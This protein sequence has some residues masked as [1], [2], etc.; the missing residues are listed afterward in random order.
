MGQRQGALHLGALLWR[1]GATRQR[2]GAP[3]A[4]LAERLGD[5]RQVVEHRH[6]QV[7]GVGLGVQA[8]ARGIEHVDQQIELD[9]DQ[10]GVA[11]ETLEAVD[12]ALD[13]VPGQGLPGRRHGVAVL[14]QPRQ[15]ISPG[16]GGDLLERSL[17]GRLDG[18]AAGLHRLVAA[19]FA[20]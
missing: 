5:R 19:Q 20:G 1:E 11:L 14:Q 16:G 15:F 2:R 12:G 18:C 7:V 9:R 8:Q 4:Q 17:N 10:L 13:H 6:R 3:G